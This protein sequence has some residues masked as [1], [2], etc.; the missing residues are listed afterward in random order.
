M[1]RIRRKRKSNKMVLYLLLAVILFIGIALF[2]KS[3][4]FNISTISVEGTETL[5]ISDIIELS[6]LKTGTNIF[7]FRASSVENSLS[8]ESLVKSVEIKRVYPD[9][10][11]IIITERTP[12]ITVSDN[13]TYYY[14]D[15]DGMV[16]YTSSSL[17]NDCGIILSGTTDV[18]LIKGEFFNYNSNV[19]TM[20]AFNIA[21]ILKQTKVYD[22]VS[23]IY[24][25]Q[26]GYYYLYT[27]KS[28]VIKFYSLSSFESNK[29][30]IADFILNEDRHIM[31]EVIEDSEP[32][33]KV[34]DIK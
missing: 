10:V 14:L 21:D 17:N 5:H 8:T 13:S 2:C 3:N 25:S 9:E 20:T 24:V 16:I 29:D 23:E 19:N 4:V 1:R 30:F 28:N 31:I 27:E 32:V 26:S 18:S 12:Y 34:I 11:R 15:E 33:Y 6:G 22:Y 7:D